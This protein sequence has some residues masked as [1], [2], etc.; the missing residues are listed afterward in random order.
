LTER[1]PRAVGVFKNAATRMTVVVG[2][3][4]GAVLAGWLIE[5]YRRRY[6]FYINFGRAALDAIITQQVQIIAYIDD[7]KLPM[8]ATRLASCRAPCLR[9]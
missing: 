2:P 3:V 8:I 5:N 1:N 6:I 7:D 9:S 4:L